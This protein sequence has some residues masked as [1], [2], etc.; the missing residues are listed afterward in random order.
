MERLADDRIDR[1][2]IPDDFHD[3][4]GRQAAHVHLDRMRDP[5]AVPSRGCGPESPDLALDVRGQEIA[6]PS[7]FVKDTCGPSSNRNPAPAS[8]VAMWPPG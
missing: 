1:H 2:E 3:E 8:N 7:S 5:R 6:D 4:V